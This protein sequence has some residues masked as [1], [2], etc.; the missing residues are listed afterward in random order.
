MSF[1][2]LITFGSLLSIAAIQVFW[3][4]S[5]QKKHRYKF[6]DYFLYSTVGS[7]VYGLINFG[8]KQLISEIIKVEMDVIV[9]NQIVTTIGL[10][11]LMAAFYFLLLFY[12]ELREGKCYK[13]LKVGYWI[14]QLI[15]FTVYVY[16][17][18]LILNQR[19]L[20][21][22]YYLF[23]SL[24]N[25]Q[26]LIVLSIYLGNL[27]LVKFVTTKLKRSF[28]TI[29]IVADLL[30]FL[31]TFI[32]LEKLNLSFYLS[33]VSFYTLIS[34][35]YFLTTFLPLIIVWYYLKKYPNL[36]NRPNEVSI[37]GEFNFSKFGI[38]TREQEIVNLVTKGKTNDEIAG[39]LF[40][41]AQTVKNTLSSIYKKTNVRN[42][43]ELRNL[44]N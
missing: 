11:F 34:H 16:I 23:Y 4:T 13:I 17:V 25:S 26:F 14:T 8:G 28:V 6:L 19:E 37:K 30:S 32:A 10:P 42:R 43:V 15:A 38:T 44:I 3:I 7:S 18:S 41:S 36:Y 21:E 5:L 35:I 33:A 29:V 27:Y 24:S 20:F 31:L 9:V 2:F 12:T 40:I 39:I 22:K 1:Q